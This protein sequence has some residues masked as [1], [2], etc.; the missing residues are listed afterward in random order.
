MIWPEEAVTN[1]I[2]Q[3]IHYP[4]ALQVIDFSTADLILVSV[5]T[6]AGSKMA[7]KTVADIH[8]VLPD[9]KVQIIVSISRQKVQRY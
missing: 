2:V 7:G 1:S 4:E 5:K 9:A 3:L 6:D 8:Q